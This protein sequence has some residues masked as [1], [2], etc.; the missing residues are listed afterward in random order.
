MEKWLKRDEKGSHD[1]QNHS[2]L[3]PQDSRLTVSGY[4]VT[5]FLRRVPFNT[6]YRY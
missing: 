2:L 5:N 3:N 6:F 1:L 4:F